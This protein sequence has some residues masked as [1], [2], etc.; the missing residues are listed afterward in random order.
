MPGASLKGNA[1][2]VWTLFAVRL[3]IATFS[4]VMES[5]GAAVI[6]VFAPRCV[7]S[8]STAAKLANSAGLKSI[9]SCCALKPLIVER[10]V[11]QG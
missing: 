4:S 3:V 7:A 1:P 9:W 10:R 6:I 2:Y 11:Q 8:C 5:P